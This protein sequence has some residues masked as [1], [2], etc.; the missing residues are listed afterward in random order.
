MTRLLPALLLASAAFTPAAI[1]APAQAA[2]FDCAK[3]GS[4]FEKAICGND[5]LSEKD[6][7]LA[8]A[9]ATAQGGLSEDAL[10]ILRDGQRQWLNMTQRAC[11][12]DAEPARVAYDQQGSQCIANLYDARIATLENSRMMGGLR[13]YTADLF[14]VAPDP[15]GTDYSKVATKKLSYLRVDGTSELAA[16]FNAWMAEQ[17]EDIATRIA[18]GPSGEDFD[19][20]SDEAISIGAT[21]VNMYVISA[22][23]IESWYG[24]G[25]AHGNYSVSYMH[26]LKEKN[27]PVQ[28]SDVFAAAGWEDKLTA[29]VWQQLQRD[30]GEYLQAEGPED[31]KKQVTSVARWD[32]SSEGIGIAFQP[33][34]VASYADGARTVTISWQSIEDLTTSEASAYGWH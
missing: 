23:L 16:G 5:N 7:V 31:I 9:Y 1:V 32:F 34:E 29:M 14:A 11:T 12:D 2:S 22:E 3:A 25:A 19:V 13:F 24:H 8:V 4:F 17:T 28:A 21:S 27:R 10:A 30:L 15:D 6:R 26:Y 20:T 33:Y 18:A